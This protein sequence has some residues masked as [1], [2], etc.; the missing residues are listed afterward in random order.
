MKKNFADIL[1]LDKLILQLITNRMILKLTEIKK[2]DKKIINYVLFY[3][4]NEGLKNEAIK[5]F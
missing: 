5:C 3:G 1:F 2:I 4:K